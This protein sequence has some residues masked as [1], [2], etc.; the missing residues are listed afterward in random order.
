MLP[1]WSV[2]L[3]VG[4][5][6]TR[7]CWRRWTI[8]P[9]APAPAGGRRL[10][11]LDARRRGRRAARLGRLRVLGIAARPGATRAGDPADLRLETAE[12]AALAS[13]AVAVAAGVLVVRPLTRAGRAAR[14]NPAAGAAGAAAGVL[15]CAVTFAVWLLNPYA[16]ALLL[17][18]AHLWLLLGVPQTRMRGAIAWLA[19]GA[20]CAPAEPAYGARALRA[21]PL[22]LARMWLV[23]T[24]AAM[25]R[26]GRRSR[27][28]CSRAA[29]RRSCGSC[30]RAGGSR[31]PRRPSS[32]TRAARPAPRGRARWAAPSPRCGAERCAASCVRYRSC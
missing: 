20:A 7:R 13:V 9:R 27:S 14:G 18:A 8:L 22:E 11:H 19:L 25:S 23:A 21:G 30:W 31:P 15:V 24:A 4:A 16:A 17:P 12:A 26:P 6:C 28:A 29:S 2:R 1:G 32:C 3:L 10:A 5:W